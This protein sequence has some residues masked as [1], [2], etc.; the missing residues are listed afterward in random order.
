MH[1]NLLCCRY[2]ALI[3]AHSHR[4]PHTDEWTIDGIEYAGNHA[5]DPRQL[6]VSKAIWQLYRARRLRGNGR[7]VVN[8]VLHPMCAALNPM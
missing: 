3:E 1:T 2:L 4:D 6:S 5:N 8:T 7:P